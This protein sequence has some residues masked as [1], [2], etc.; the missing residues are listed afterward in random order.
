MMLLNLI[1]QT[2]FLLNMTTWLIMIAILIILLPGPKGRPFLFYLFLFCEQLNSIFSLTSF[3][4]SF[5]KGEN[6]S[7]DVHLMHIITII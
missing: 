1:D 3:A 6:E 2:C 5:G 7:V 4:I